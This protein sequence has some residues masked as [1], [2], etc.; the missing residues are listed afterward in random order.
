MAAG[1]YETSITVFCAEAGRLA[2]RPVF[3]FTTSLTISQFR[4]IELSITAV[5]LQLDAV[6]AIQLPRDLPSTTLYQSSSHALPL[7]S[8]DLTKAI[9]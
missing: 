7:R 8:D 6:Q 4:A 2:R 3:N 9:I 1:P 5:T